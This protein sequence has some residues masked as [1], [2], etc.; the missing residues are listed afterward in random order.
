MKH[1]TLAA[2]TAD[3]RR[4][5]SPTRHEDD[6]QAWAMHQAAHLKSGRFLDLVNLAD[7]IADVGHS[8]Y[9]KVVI[10][11]AGVIQHLLKWDHQPPFPSRSWANSIREHRRRVERQLSR[12]PSLKARTSDI[13]EEAHERG[14][15]D[16]LIETGLDEAD[17]P[18][19]CPFAWDEVVSRPVAWPEP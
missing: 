2:F 15:G 1:D 6:L 16:A 14:R 12:V 10:D 19:A 4:D 9:D 17:L 18:E 13:L 3:G 8:Q 7:E 11:L 5:A